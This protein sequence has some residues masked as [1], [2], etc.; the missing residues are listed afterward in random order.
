MS[1][2]RASVCTFA[3]PC[4]KLLCPQC[5][6]SRGCLVLRKQN[7]CRFLH[8][9]ADLE[10]II[11]ARKCLHTPCPTMCRRMLV[12]KAP[13]CK[14]SWRANARLRGCC[15]GKEYNPTK[16]I[17]ILHPHN[18]TVIFSRKCHPCPYSG[19]RRIV[20]AYRLRSLGSV[21]SLLQVTP[22][23]KNNIQLFFTALTKNMFEMRA[24]HSLTSFLAFSVT[25]LR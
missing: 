1:R 25:L 22:F 10:K 15:V 18:P 4:K 8:R 24:W 3:S 2:S 6:G 21:Y 23:V 11:S 9:K 7:R 20:V 14:G 12:E 13:L 5:G 17:C 19:H 16:R